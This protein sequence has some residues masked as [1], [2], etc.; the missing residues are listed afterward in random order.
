MKNKNAYYIV[1]R[2]DGND[3]INAY[4]SN[5]LKD[6]ASWLDITYKNTSQYL[7]KDLNNINSKLKHLY[8]HKYF[9]FKDY[10]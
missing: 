1:Y 3:I 5:N 2:V 6:V 8:N 4:D 9:I 10:E 7:V